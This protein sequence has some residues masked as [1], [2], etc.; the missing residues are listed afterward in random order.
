MDRRT[1]VEQVL[2]NLRRVTPD[3]RAA[4][5]EELDGHIEDHICDLLELGYDEKLAEERAM[6][7]MGD[8]EEVGRELDKQYP[9]RWLVLG[10][11]ALVLTAMMCVVAVLGFGILSHLWW[12]IEARIVTDAVASDFP[13]QNRQTVDIRVSV[14]NDILRIYRVATGNQ[15]GQLVAEV[16]M[17]AYDRVP[18]GIASGTLLPNVKLTDQRGKPPEWGNHGARGKSNWGADYKVKS[19]D[20][21]PGDT[22]VT[23]TYDRFGEYVSVQVPLTGEDAP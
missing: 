19:I 5:R 9:L 23:L 15:D 18:G 12:S 3:E 7:A 22:Y 4:I 21:E 17:C 11:A 16:A 6:A 13:E 8:P 2:A 20:I 1:Y 10:R 14:G